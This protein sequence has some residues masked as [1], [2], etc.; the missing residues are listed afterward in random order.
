VEKLFTVTM[1]DDKIKLHGKLMPGLRI[2]SL[3]F[4]GIIF[5][6][7]NQCDGVIKGGSL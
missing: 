1:Q 4:K 5:R 2:S 7:L 3:G 6:P